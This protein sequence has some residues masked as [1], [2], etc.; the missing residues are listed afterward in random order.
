[1]IEL[2]HLVYFQAV[3]ELGSMARAAA[4]LRMTQPALGRQIAQLERSVGHQLLKR[5]HR[6]T[7]LTPAGER[8][9]R[10]VHVIFTQV[11]RIPEVL[12]TELDV[13]HVHLG[14]PPG[15]PTEWLVDVRDDLRERAPHI[16]LLLHEAPSEIQRVMLRNG[17]IDIGLIHLRPPDVPSQVVLTQRFGCAVRHASRLAT[18]PTIRLRDLHGLRVM[19]RSAQENPQ[20]ETRLRAAADA[21]G[22]EIE[23][24]FRSFA[25]YGELI[26]DTSQVDVVLL[27]RV[28]AGRHFS[29]WTWVP[30]DTADGDNAFMYTWAIWTD[31]GPDELPT[32]LAAMSRA[33]SPSLAVDSEDRESAT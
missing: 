21:L 27:S 6:G 19:A 4:S 12:G 13:T 25:E 28:S 26:A 7:T 32:V 31:N 29:K 20:Q 5:T 1:M 2:R 16:N 8:F 15:V 14:V 17:L 24:V 33:T 23:W 22:A 9:R 10:H 18:R 11:E 30:I 3:A